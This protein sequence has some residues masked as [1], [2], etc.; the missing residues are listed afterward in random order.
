MTNVQAPPVAAL[1]LAVFDQRV[2][3]TLAWKRTVPSDLD[4]SGVEYHSLPSGLHGVQS[5]VVYFIHDGQYAAVSAFAQEKADE[6]HRNARFCAVGALVPLSYGKLGRSWLYAPE[7][8]RL[9]REYLSNPNDMR[10]LELFWTKHK[11]GSKSDARSSSPTEHRGS[12]NANLKRKRGLSDATP[13]LGLDATTAA[14]HPSLYMSSLLDSFGP[15]IFPLHR[16]ALLRKRILLLGAPPLQRNCSAVYILSILSNLPAASTELLQPNT[17]AIHRS[18]PLFSIG[19]N[20]IP[21]LTSNVDKAGYIATSTDDIL[22]EKHQLYDILVELTPGESGSKRR[23]PRLR[24]SDGKIIKATQRDLRRYRRL[25]SELRQLRLARNR[26]RDEASDNDNDNATDVNEQAPLIRTDSLLNHSPTTEPLTNGE[27]EVVEPPT[28]TAIAYTSLMFWATYGSA[29]AT[30]AA[31][32]ETNFDA[33]LL[34]D[35]PDL[36]DALS[37]STTL[38]PSSAKNDDAAQMEEAQE[39]AT[40]LTA[41][42]HRL[43]D[44]I[45]QALAEIVAEADDETET[46]VEEDAIVI[47]GE[48][49]RGMGL[50]GSSE[51]DREFVRGM[52]ELY[53]GRE[54]KVAEGEG[55]W[56]CGVRVC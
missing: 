16:A 48:E 10:S 23:W 40:V 20:D 25:R 44:R 53:F 28:W 26:Y 24:T 31:D 2:G 6:T 50:D 52:M 11:Q 7:L 12:V 37:N 42:F 33:S 51:G 32:G 38:P 55:V 47:S 46:G 1:F 22:G 3:Y 15:L 21:A 36:H 54:A 30:A 13:V 43:T 4:L 19:I 45:V 49:V 35:L 56:V 29:E 34:E 18:H 5:D 8:R 17:E 9:A 41:Y 39:T 27:H 14:D